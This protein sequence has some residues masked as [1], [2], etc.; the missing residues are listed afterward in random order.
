[1][2]TGTHDNDTTIGWYRTAPKHE[3]E[4]CHKY[5]HT[6]GSDIAWDMIR[7]IWQSVA[8]FALAPMQDFLRLDGESRMNF[9]GKPAGNWCWRMTEDQLSPRLSEQ[10]YELN[11]I[12]GR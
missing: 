3:L 5:L 6:D 11:R 10:I 4:Y 2:Y 1:V 7:A 8:R 9:P 12:Y